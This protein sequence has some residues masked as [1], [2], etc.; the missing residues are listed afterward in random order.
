M[1][2]SE[3]RIKGGSIP[4]L[5]EL[6]KQ[7]VE[8]LVTNKVD[9]EDGKGLSTND[10][11]TPEKEK[12]ALINGRTDN[13][14][15]TAFSSTD[16]NFPT[17]RSIYYGLPYFNNSKS[18]NS[19]TKLYAP[20][21]GG[22]S[23]YELVGNGASS[24]PIW[25]APNYVSCTTAGATVAKVATITNFKLV[26]GVTVRV[27]FNYVNTATNATLNISNTGAKPI[28]YRGVAVDAAN[29]WVANEVLDLLYNGTEWI[30]IGSSQMLVYQS[31]SSG[32]VD[33]LIVPGMYTCN[34]ISSTPAQFGTLIV[35]LTDVGTDITS[36]HITHI[37][38]EEGSNNI[39]MRYKS[40]DGNAWSWSEWSKVVRD[41]TDCTTATAIS[42]TDDNIITSR[43]VYYGMPTING[44]HIYN[45]NTNIYVPT[46]AGTAG[47]NLISNGSGAPVWQPPLYAVCST[48]AA[49][50]AKEVTITNFKLVT[51]VHIFVKFTNGHNAKTAATLNV[52][53]TGA[54]K[55]I[56]G[57]AF[58]Y[59]LSASNSSIMLLTNGTYELM[60]DGTNWVIMNVDENMLD[61][62]P[63]YYFKMLTDANIDGGVDSLYYLYVNTSSGTRDIQNLTWTADI[64][65]DKDYLKFKGQQVLYGNTSNYITNGVTSWYAPTSVGSNAQYLKSTGSG[66]PTWASFSGLT[67]SMNGSSS[68]YYPY[69]SVSKTWYAPTSAGTSGHTLVSNGSGAPVWQAPPY[70]TCSIAAGT[71]AK[72]VTVTNFKKLT[73]SR[74]WVKFTYNNTV[75]SP[76]LNVNSTGASQIKWGNTTTPPNNYMW[77]AGD[78]VEFIYDG[79]NYVAI[80]SSSVN[81][82]Y[83]T[84]NVTIKNNSA[85]GTRLNFGDANYCYLYEWEDDKL[86]VHGSTLRMHGAIELTLGIGNL[87]NIGADTV[88]DS[89]TQY[90]KITSNTISLGTG[91]AQNV[92]LRGT[93]TT[94]TPKVMGMV[95]NSTASGS[96]FSTANDKGYNSVIHVSAVEPTNMSVGDLWFKIP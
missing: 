95:Y 70:G 40:Y 36:V 20:T 93:N 38:V 74:V 89:S 76:T 12:V 9:V 48:A 35:V 16:T 44:S 47:H 17:V 34:S 52:S 68:T 96:T 69:S 50:V 63:A 49:T 94:T 39:W 71:A 4:K 86:A 6:I 25:K 61:W 85:F 92:L 8:A 56:F 82:G 5:V 14:S 62:D 43:A 15:A 54:K 65:F 37:F 42:S 30:A 1:D 23:G 78:I 7:K 72:T 51:G 79:S 57:S 28:K 45:S 18:Y 53:G 81:Q 55:I 46:S 58:T 2:T 29:S 83:F 66:N 21:A 31:I 60:Y 75:A 84:G 87:S 90:V 80:A 88:S 3:K 33:T 10:Y 77:Q 32:D 41:V 67:L 26:S 91:T 11:T 59:D 24:A 73:G 64:N 27:K 22:T 19:N 13:S